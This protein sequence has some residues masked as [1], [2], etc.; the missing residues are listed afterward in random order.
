MKREEKEAT[1]RMLGIEIGP[2]G[3]E[4]VK[5]AA[6][7]IVSIITVYMLLILMGLL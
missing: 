5:M 1:I 7:Y 6:T 3:R 2:I 4:Y